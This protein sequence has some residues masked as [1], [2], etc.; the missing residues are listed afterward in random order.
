MAAPPWAHASHGAV[1]RWQGEPLKAG[2]VVPD[3]VAELLRD[4]NLIARGDVPVHKKLQ[5]ATQ[6]PSPMAFISHCHDPVAA[7]QRPRGAC[8]ALD[9]GERVSQELMG[10]L[11]A[12]VVKR[13]WVLLKR[14]AGI[15]GAVPSVASV[16]EA[17][18][19]LCRRDAGRKD[20]AAIAALHIACD[21]LGVGLTLYGITRV[22]EGERN[23]CLLHDGRRW[24]TEASRCELRAQPARTQTAA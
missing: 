8:S 19:E 16:K 18:V 4:A 22:S 1:E 6:S 24:D 3:T 2:A 20:G 10:R 21:M 11:N 12:D 17:S 5:P 7:W 15:K 9:H 23:A 13:T 14:T